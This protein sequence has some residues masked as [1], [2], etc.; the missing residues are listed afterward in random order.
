MGE[1]G[2]HATDG[3][4]GLEAFSAYSRR[5]VTTSTNCASATRRRVRRKHSKT[6]CRAKWTAGGYGI[7]A[8][9]GNHTTDL[10]GGNSGKQY[11]LPNY[12]F[13]D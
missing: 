6:A 11:L 5:P 9:I 8:N 13:L 7:I 4:T 1:Q 3:P 10:A 2:R 12:G